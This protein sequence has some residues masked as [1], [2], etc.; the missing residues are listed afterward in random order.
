[1]HMRT[2]SRDKTIHPLLIFYRM[3]CTKKRKR[4]EYGSRSRQ[5]LLKT[6]GRGC[7]KSKFV[8]WHCK[9]AFE[10]GKACVDGVCGECKIAHDKNG[11]KCHVCNQRIED[12]RE[13]T[14]ITYMPRN[15]KNW[16]GPGPVTCAI[17][18]I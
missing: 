6:Y 10:S 1:M 13:T 15:R 18:D 11:H 17:C 12:Y 16:K 8:V 7:G 5:S 3:K 14:L 9:D 4:N 2:H